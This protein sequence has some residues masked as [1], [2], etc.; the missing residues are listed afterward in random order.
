MHEDDIELRQ[1]ISHLQIHIQYYLSLLSHDNLK[2]DPYQKVLYEALKDQ[3]QQELFLNGLG[4]H[5]LP[6]GN[7]LPMETI[8]G[9]NPALCTALLNNIKKF[10]VYLAPYDAIDHQRGLENELCVLKTI[11]YNHRDRLTEST[12]MSTENIKLRHLLG[13]FLQPLLRPDPP[14]ALQDNYAKAEFFYRKHYEFFKKIPEL[15]SNKSFV[16]QIDSIFLKV[17]YYSK[18]EKV[19]RYLQLNVEF[20]NAPLSKDADKF[21]QWCT[22]QA[23][24]KMNDLSNDL[25]ALLITNTSVYVEAIDA[26]ITFR[27]LNHTGKSFQYA[28]GEQGLLAGNTHFI[29]ALLFNDATLLNVFHNGINAPNRWYQFWTLNASIEQKSSLK[30]RTALCHFG[31]SCQEYNRFIQVSLLD[32]KPTTPLEIHNRIVILNKLSLLSRIQVIINDFEMMA[33][34]KINTIHALFNNAAHQKT[35]SACLCEEDERFIE[36]VHLF[37]NEVSL[38][39]PDLSKKSTLVSALMLAP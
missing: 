7:F 29:R 23:L 16:D 6:G 24:T 28:M 39:K 34:L 3:K 13:L 18:V 37:F 14:Y 10:P 12:L 27:T 36:D 4:E 5:G 21:Q 1:V 35:L 25:V 32:R 2:L 30:H 20:Y 8:L 38:P 9:T 26:K 31:E 22:K 19:I 33:P 15:A 17:N 11:I